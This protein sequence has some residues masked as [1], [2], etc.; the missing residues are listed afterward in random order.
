MSAIVVGM[1]SILLGSLAQ[2]QPQQPAKPPAPLRVSTRLIP[3]FVV[4]EKDQLTGFSIELWRGIAAQ[5]GI[6]SEFS[7]QTTLPDMLG[8]VKSGKADLGI[9]AVS[10]T[11]KRE[12]EYDFSQPIFESGL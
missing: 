7:V 12:E 3:P 10:I 9:A 11:A 6:Q 1:F 4:T 5:T 8:E 2:A